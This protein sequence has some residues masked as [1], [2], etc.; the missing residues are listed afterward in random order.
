[1][2]EL[3]QMIHSLVY[4]KNLVSSHPYGFL[5]F[6]LMQIWRELVLMELVY[7]ANVLVL[8]INE[9]KIKIKIKIN[10]KKNK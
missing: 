2:L 5:V 9:I 7:I 6:S 8:K 3:L 1:M 4:L 10:I